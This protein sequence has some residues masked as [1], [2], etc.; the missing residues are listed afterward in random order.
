MVPAIIAALGAI[1]GSVISHSSNRKSARDQNRINEERF[2]AQNAYNI[3]MWNRQN[4]YNHP[5]LQ[6]QRFEEAGINPAL[7]LGAFTSGQAQSVTSATPAP[8]VGPAPRA[9]PLEALVS[10]LPSISQAIVAEAQANKLNA[11]TRG[12]DINNETLS[13][14]NN[15]NLNKII[16]ETGLLDVQTGHFSKMTDIALS[17]ELRKK[18]AHPLAM[19]EMESRIAKTLSEK[20]F[21]DVQTAVEKFNLRELKPMEKRA[22]QMSILVSQATIRQLD[23]VT[24]LNKEQKQYVY[25]MAL[26]ESE[27]RLGIKLDNDLKKATF[28]YQIHKIDSEVALNV[29]K[30]KYLRGARIQGWVNIGLNTLNTAAN[31]V[32]TV[33]TRGLGGARNPIGFGASSQSAPSFLERFSTILGFGK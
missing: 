21:I 20:D 28:D 10:V 14:T 25:Q 24:E 27:K 26:T 18:E 2:N 29:E 8:A 6:R 23:S 7:A 19:L 5:L 3:E 1:A 33:M 31:V 22:M 30:R 4:A 15:A 16:S 32:S 11:E 17:E 9:N 12:I 13:D